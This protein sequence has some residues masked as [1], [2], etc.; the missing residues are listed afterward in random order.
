MKQQLLSHHFF[1]QWENAD[2]ENCVKIFCDLQE[3]TIDSRLKRETVSSPYNNDLLVTELHWNAFQAD[4]WKQTA[5]TE[6]SNEQEVER[7]H[8]LFL[9]AYILITKLLIKRRVRCIKFQ[10]DL[11]VIV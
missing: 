2:K 3:K 5:D 9:F 10:L 6:A 4:M 1:S 8:L 11:I 7:I